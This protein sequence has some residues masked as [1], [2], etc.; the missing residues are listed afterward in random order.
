MMSKKQADRAALRIK[1]AYSWARRKADAVETAIHDPE[2]TEEA[3]DAL[4]EAED[5]ALDALADAITEGTAGAVTPGE[6]DRLVRHRFE[7][8]GDLVAR[9][10]V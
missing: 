1:S 10:T 6:A 9:L 4:L 2:I 5:R 7:A 8:V 3:F